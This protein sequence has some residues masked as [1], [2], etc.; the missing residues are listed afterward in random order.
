M[1]RLIVIS[2][3]LMIILLN[4]CSKRTVPSKG[5]ATVTYEYDSS[6]IKSTP[7][8][9]P[10]VKKPV[11]KKKP[12][13]ALPKVI[14]V[15]DVAAKKSVDGRLYYDVEGKRYWKNFKDGKYYLFDK[16]MYN[17][18]DFKPPQ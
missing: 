4:S 8:P 1:Q 3:I 10:V 16:T 5:P 7:D 14:S 15:N 18:P 13:P 6:A 9:A 12:A 11:E 17:N 2:G